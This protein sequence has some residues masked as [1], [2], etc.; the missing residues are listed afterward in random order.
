M[1][2]E[3]L[4]DNTEVT[5]R[6]VCTV[7]DVPFHEDMLNPYSAAA[8]AIQHVRGESGIVAS[9][10]C[11]PHQR[12]PALHTM[13][14]EHSSSLCAFLI[15]GSYSCTHRLDG[16]RQPVR[17]I[18]SASASKSVLSLQLDLPHCRLSSFHTSPHRLSSGST[19]AFS[20]LPC[21]LH[22]STDMC[23]RIGQQCSRRASR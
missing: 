16:V 2:Y 20:E 7:L 5:L 11:D 18:R 17:G 23:W 10:P 8:T 12:Y 15:A 19:S 21:R 6:K 4:M 3:Q 14:S 22:S 13:P 1:S 9:D